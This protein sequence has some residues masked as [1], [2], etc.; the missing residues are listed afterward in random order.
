MTR[1]I[2][3]IILTLPFL[4]PATLLAKP[5]PK[6]PESEF[7]AVDVPPNSVTYPLPEITVPP[8]A[9]FV[10]A[11][12]SEEFRLSSVYEN[13]GKAGKMEH[14]D[15][16][17]SLRAKWIE[18][19]KGNNPNLAAKAQGEY[20]AS[21][22]KDLESAIAIYDSVVSVIGDGGSGTGGR[23]DKEGND[24][25]ADADQ[26]AAD[27]RRTI[28]AKSVAFYID[29]TNTDAS[30]FT[31]ED[32]MIQEVMTQINT[33][34]NITMDGAPGVPTAIRLRKAAQLARMLRARNAMLVQS[35]KQ[36]AQMAILRV[37]TPMGKDGLPERLDNPLSGAAGNE[38]VRTPAKFVP[39][40]P[41]GG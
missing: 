33:A 22:R 41:F 13:I 12:D 32:A 38:R 16:T 31:P 24:A 26:I 11:P 8:R 2:R 10:E 29:S 7:K 3:F 36:A 30:V 23:S 35:C 19:S 39:T 25:K 40:S 27:V 4:A 17:K 1:L 20:L 21:Y 6:P 9:G 18:A 15:V 28:A 5:T 14:S 37:A 34:E